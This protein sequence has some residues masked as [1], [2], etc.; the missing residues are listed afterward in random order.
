MGY[1]D[2]DGK[3][4]WDVRET[5]KWYTDMRDWETNPLPSDASRRKDVAAMKTKDVAQA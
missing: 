3:R 4:Y 2:F 5:D 1:L